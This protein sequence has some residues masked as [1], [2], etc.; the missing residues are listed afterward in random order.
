[1]GAPTITQHAQLRVC[2][3]CS[4]PL[5]SERSSAPSIFLF[6]AN[7]A[8]MADLLQTRSTISS[9]AAVEHKIPIATKSGPYYDT[10]EN[11]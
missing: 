8:A 9:R 4:R 2:I 1:M 5:L 7:Q 3:V 10:V 6:A 11:F